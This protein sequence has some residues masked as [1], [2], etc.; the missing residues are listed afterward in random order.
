MAKNYTIAK[1]D[2]GTIQITYTIAFPEIQKARE[3]AALDLGKDMEIAGFRKGMAPLA[4]LLEKIPAQ[5]LIEKALNGMLPKLFGDTIDEEKLKPI[6]YPKFELIKADENEPWQVVA[7]TAEL[8]NFELG[9]YKATVKGATVKIWKPGD[10]KKEESQTR[11]QKEQEV[12]KALLS[13]VKIKIPKILLDEEVNSRLSKLL[14]QID[15]LGLTLDSYLA[16]I[17][18]KT[19]D[20]RAEYEKQAESALS[21][22]FIL[23]KISALEGIKVTEE[24]IAEAIKVSSNSDAELAKRLE[25]P[26]QKRLIESILL[27]RN[28]LNKLISFV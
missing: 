9:D 15:K 24:E 21:L 8:P 22:D 17:G 19:E 7:T 20:V 16:S 4:R 3:N 11:E 28:T 2:D 14:E 23:V 5:T 26:E 27:K 18:K 13:Q 10:D 25:T 12:I 1:S 6:A